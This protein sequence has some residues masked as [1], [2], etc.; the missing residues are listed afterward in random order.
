MQLVFT[1]MDI[2]R[3]RVFKNRL[4]TIF[5]PKRD[6]FVRE[7]KKLYE[8]LLSLDTSQDII[9]VMNEGG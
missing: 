4:M 7:R 6:G 5:V 3:L 8:V 2:H 1:V 9:R